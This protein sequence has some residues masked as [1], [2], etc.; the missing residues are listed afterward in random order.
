MADTIEAGGCGVDGG[1][2][3][4]RPKAENERLDIV[5]NI[6]IGLFLAQCTH[7][8]SRLTI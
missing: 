1:E 2:D 3:D 6:Y 7:Y 5:T 8:L 4:S